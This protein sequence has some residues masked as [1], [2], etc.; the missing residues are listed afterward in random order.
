VPRKPRLEAPGATFH[1][2]AN[3]VSGQTIV[4]DDYDRRTL[5]TR[6]SRA[7][8]RYRWRC[9]AY[10]ILDTHLHLVVRTPETNLGRGMQWLSGR[11][12]ESFNDRHRRAGHVFGGRFYSGHLESDDHLMAALIYVLLNPV[13]A[14]VVPHAEDWPWSSY[15]ATVGEVPAPAFLDVTGVL[16][17]VDARPRVASR[18]LAAAVAEAA[19]VERGT[20]RL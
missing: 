18:R 4:R 12:A 16:G 2:V 10:C 6:L 5:V 20:G 13:R 11:Y 8:E 19:R 7:V 3:A 17:L 9:L 14:G 15:A 1:V